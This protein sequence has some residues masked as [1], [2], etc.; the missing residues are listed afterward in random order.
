[1]IGQKRFLKSITGPP[2]QAAEQLYLTPW[3]KPLYGFLG[4]EELSGGL[5]CGRRGN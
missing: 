4:E 5:K 3:L 1:M 2:A